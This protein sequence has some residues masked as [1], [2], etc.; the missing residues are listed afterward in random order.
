[1]K[2]KQTN[3]SGAC[4]LTQHKHADERGYFSRNYCQKTF[5]DLGLSGGFIQSSESWNTNKGTLRG[6]HFQSSPY[7]E[8]KL[9]RC[10]KGKL[11]D[12]ILDLRKSSKTYLQHFCIELKALDGNIIYVPKGV[13]H[14]FLTL[15][16]DTVIGY[17]MLEGEYSA[18]HATGVRW[19]DPKFKIEW[20][21]SPTVIS[22]KDASF[23]NH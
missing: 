5:T 6:L 4:V 15:E 16:E 3:I 19:D 21:F 7:E 18:Q 17:S 14:G 2:V 10:I 9:V 23:K 8:V 11:F 13:A 1:M 12:V 20:P 22:E